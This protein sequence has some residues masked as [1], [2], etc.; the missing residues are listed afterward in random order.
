ML[1]PQAYGEAIADVYDDWYGDV[2]DVAGTV[3]TVT[4][5]AAGGAVLE[6]GIGT[7]RLALPLHAAGVEVLENHGVEAWIL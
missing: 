1:E 5:L 4:A 3:T 7:G 2:S 6:L